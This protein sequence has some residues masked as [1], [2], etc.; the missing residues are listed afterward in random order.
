MDIFDGDYPN[1][2]YKSQTI[3]EKHYRVDTFYQ[4]E[5]INEVGKI[6]LYIGNVF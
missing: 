4:G 3:L 5:D 2:G 6:D 1:Q